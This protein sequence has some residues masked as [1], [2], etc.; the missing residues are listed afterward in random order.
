MG[1]IVLRR[2]VISDGKQ[3]RDDNS[4]Q[5]SSFRYPDMAETVHADAIDSPVPPRGWSARRRVVD[6]LGDDRGRRRWSG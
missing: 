4:S 3:P 2:S 1:A 6:R 5:A